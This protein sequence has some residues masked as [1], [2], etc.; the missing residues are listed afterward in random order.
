MRILIA[1]PFTK[2]NQG[3]AL[4]VYAEGLEG[5]FRRA[6]HV[7][8]FAPRSHLEEILPQGVRHFVY[9]ARIMPLVWRSDAVL[10]LDAWSTG[11]P[12][13]LAAR[14]F[15]KKFGIRIGGD[16]LWESY[17]E[18]TKEPVL[19]SEFYQ[20]PR[21]LSFKERIISR[22]LRS[23]TRR[24]DALLFTTRFQ[25]DIWQKA[26]DFPSGR[27]YIVE[28]YYPQPKRGGPLRGN[29]FVSAGRKMFLKNMDLLERAFARVAAH[30]SGISLDTRSLPHEEHLRRLEGA[31][32]VVVPTFSEVCSNT[33]IEAVSRGKPFIMSKDTGTRE[34]LEQCGMFIDTRN[35]DELE[36]A[37]E[38]ILDPVVYG[39]L[40]S[41]SMSFS[42]EHSWDDMAKEI[43]VILSKV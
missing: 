1:T 9:A 41:A 37:I 18:R 4:G 26:Y 35:E 25:R 23:L 32:A 8:A 28:N 13:L 6:G 30:H 36:R 20:A 16:F 34:R 7:V 31:Y 5:A 14:L 21:A 43:G 29:I 39:K 10:A 40:S 3:E 15:R 11:F 38:Q 24:A 42:H 17:V 27:A 22:G 12:A 19:L 2:K 33:A